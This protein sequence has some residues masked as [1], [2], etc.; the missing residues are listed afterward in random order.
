MLSYGDSFP[1]P[2]GPTTIT[3]IPYLITMHVRH[4]PLTQAVHF[5]FLT[6]G[7]LSFLGFVF[8]SFAVF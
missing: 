1:Y 6:Q 4:K 2:T 5:T 7:S 8:V 3:S